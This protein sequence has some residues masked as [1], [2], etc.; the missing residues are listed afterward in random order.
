M[1]RHNTRYHR[2]KEIYFNASRGDTD[3]VYIEIRRDEV[4]G[5][6]EDLIRYGRDSKD[7]SYTL[8]V[9][10]RLEER[11]PGI[12]TLSLKKLPKHLES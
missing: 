2:L 6:M 9:G 12:V 3:V 8:V 7:V 5:L 10:C 1:K 4:E 11:S